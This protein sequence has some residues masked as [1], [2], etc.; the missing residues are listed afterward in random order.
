MRLLTVM[1]ALALLLSSCNNQSIILYNDEI[2]RY[3]Q[4][5]MDSSNKLEP[6]LVKYM[7]SENRDSL[8]ILAQRMESLS[9]G[10]VKKV[11]AMRMPKVK[12]GENFRNAC[13]RY[14]T[15]MRD[16]YTSYKEYGKAADDSTSEITQVRMIEMETKMDTVVVDLMKAQ[17]KMAKANGIK[18]ED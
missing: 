1:F 7:Q 17:Q 13:I 16:V 10:I 4:E 5:L 12:E 8:V 11:E 2:A 14:F 6:L 18:V 9:D 3:Q 15:H